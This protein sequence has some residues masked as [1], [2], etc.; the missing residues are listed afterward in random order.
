MQPQMMPMQPPTPEIQNTRKE[1]EE[2]IKKMVNLVMKVLKGKSL[3]E[4]SII[5]SD[6]NSKVNTEIQK[7]AKI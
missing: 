2:N 5:M 3:Q 6:F 7:S 4:V 1:N